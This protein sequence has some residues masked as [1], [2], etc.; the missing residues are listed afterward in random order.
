MSKRENPYDSL[1]LFIQRHK[2]G[3]MDE[4]R[5]REIIKEIIS[6]EAKRKVNEAGGKLSDNDK[7][8]Q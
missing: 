8:K 1:V 6:F 3:T 4:I 5:L 7:Q 2:I